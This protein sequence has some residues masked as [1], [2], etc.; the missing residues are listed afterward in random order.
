MVDQRLGP[1]IENATRALRRNIRTE[2]GTKSRELTELTLSNRRETLI[3]SSAGSMMTMAMMNMTP[4]SSAKNPNDSNSRD[5]EVAL[6][7]NLRPDQMN[8]LRNR[9]A[10]ATTIDPDYQADE[11]VWILSIFDK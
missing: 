8:R 11:W 1:L 6:V 9:I 4:K 7:V 5:P 3:G 10:G 2:A